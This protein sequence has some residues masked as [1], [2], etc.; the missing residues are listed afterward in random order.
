MATVVFMCSLGTATGAA[1]GHTLLLRR[2]RSDSNDST[3]H[4]FGFVH[5]INGLVELARTHATAPHRVKPS[6]IIHNLS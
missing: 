5:S 3:Q 2:L 6:C 4:A 1:P